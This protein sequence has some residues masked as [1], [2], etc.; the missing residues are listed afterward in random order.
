MTGIFADTFFFLAL[1]NKKDEADLRAFDFNAGGRPLITTI[2]VLTE[3]ADAC[4]HPENRQTF[5]QLLETL[6]QSP[7]ARILGASLEL[8][9]SGLEL[10]RKRPD[11]EWSL[12]DC[13]SFEAMRRE[14]ILEALTGDP[15]F[16]QAGF[17]A[18]LK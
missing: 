13:V 12:T 9:D 18:L 14:D 10:F 8:W 4:C 11:K 3:V 6:N 15:H 7:D 2:W 16:E 5:L 17:H 1:L